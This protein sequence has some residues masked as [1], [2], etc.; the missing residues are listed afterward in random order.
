M[1]DLAAN[2]ADVLGPVDFV[3]VEF[4]DGMAEL[5]LGLCDLSGRLFPGDPVD[6]H[7][8]PRVLLSGSCLERP[9]L[10]LDG[11][12]P[13]AVVADDPL[14]DERVDRVLHRVGA[15]AELANAG[16][17]AAR[18][19]ER[20]EHGRVDGRERI[21]NARVRRRWFCGWLDVGECHMGSAAD[22]SRPAPERSPRRWLREAR[23]LAGSQPAPQ[24]SGRIDR[25]P[26]A[27]A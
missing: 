17:L 27:A 25:Q 5:E 19:E 6:Q 18:A 12:Q 9:G 8:Q 7:A 14:P 26:S 24:T 21:G 23:T 10:G 3:V 13:A 4:P 1:P 11:G 22:A 20:V 15:L 2:R 16:L